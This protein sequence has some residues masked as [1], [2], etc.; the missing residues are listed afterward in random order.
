MESRE[1][2][3][4]DAC[5]AILVLERLFWKGKKIGCC[6]STNVT[7]EITFQKTTG[8][9]QTITKMSEVVFSLSELVVE[10]GR[11]KFHNNTSCY[12]LWKGKAPALSHAVVSSCSKS[13]LLALTW[14]ISLK[15]KSSSPEPNSAVF[16]RAVL[17][18]T[19][20]KQSEGIWIT[21]L[22]I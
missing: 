7:G 2:D 13:P 15:P 20:G 6:I 22:S 14:C 9:K 11:H 21:L 10:E 5:I 19:P 12:F 17:T 18:D 1:L 16:C 3:F 8:P 4:S